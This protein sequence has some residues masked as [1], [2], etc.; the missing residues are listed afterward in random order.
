MKL[1]S[2][3][4]VTAIVTAI[5]TTAGSFVTPASAELV[6]VCASS[7]QSEARESLPSSR[8]AAIIPLGGQ[9]R[10]DEDSLIALTRDE[11]G[12]DL[13]VN[14]G[15]S[16]EHSLRAEGAEIVGAAPDAEL[17][18]LM[19]AHH[20]GTLEHFL[21]NLDENGSGELLRISASEFPSASNDSDSVCVRPR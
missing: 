14:W 7:T 6:T 12:F 9:S 1:R 11:T 8:L 2:S 5:V 20:N 19:V 17:V 4:I 18:D 10:A 21:F 16:S 13:I 15:E 3:S